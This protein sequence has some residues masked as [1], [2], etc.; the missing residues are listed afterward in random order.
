MMLSFSCTY[1]SNQL[2]WLIICSICYNTDDWV[3]ISKYAQRFVKAGV[4]LRQTS[5]ETWMQFAAK[6]GMNILNFLFFFHIFVS[7]NSIAV[8]QCGFLYRFINWL[9]STVLK[10]F[11]LSFHILLRWKNCCFSVSKKLKEAQKI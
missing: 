2:P 4:K 7:F 1:A 9:V 5:F 11:F 6:R 8:C 10:I 3:L